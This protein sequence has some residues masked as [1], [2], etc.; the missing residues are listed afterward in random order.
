MRY[1]VGVG[2]RG[3]SGPIR[4]LALERPNHLKP[5][6]FR[7]CVTG[8]ALAKLQ[9]NMEV[10]NKNALTELSAWEISLAESSSEPEAERLSPRRRKKGI[11]EGVVGS[12]VA[13]N[14]RSST[15]GWKVELVSF[16]G[17]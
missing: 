11:A 16:G 7:V 17:P 6:G 4:L 5:K 14:E 15:F 2:G 12:Q 3:C 9:V 10:P 8:D 13:E 1:G